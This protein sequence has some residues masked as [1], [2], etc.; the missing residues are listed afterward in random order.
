MK[1]KL[2][3]T[4]NIFHVVP[5][6]RST[7]VPPEGQSAPARRRAPQFGNLWFMVSAKVLIPNVT[8]HVVFVDALA[9]SV[10]TLPVSF[11]RTI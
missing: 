11:P 3:P 7:R 5:I 10:E 9:L 4:T 2:E 6:F 1:F 8:V